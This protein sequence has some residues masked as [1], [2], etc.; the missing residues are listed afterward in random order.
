MPHAKAPIQKWVHLTHK[1]VHYGKNNVVKGSTS[2][3][4]IK[5][6]VVNKASN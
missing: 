2:T 1:N 5:N 6:V 4:V 3:T